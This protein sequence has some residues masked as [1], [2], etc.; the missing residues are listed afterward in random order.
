MLTARTIDDDGSFQVQLH[1][2]R[3][4]G[5]LFQGD[6]GGRP[7]AGLDKLP[8]PAFFYLLIGWSVDRFSHWLIGLLLDWLVG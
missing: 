8:G 2:E 7:V 4:G 6:E 1:G 5:G 3:G